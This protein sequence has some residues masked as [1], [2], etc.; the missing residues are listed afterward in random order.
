ML[1][2]KQTMAPEV[3]RGYLYGKL[4]YFRTHFKFRKE[5]RSPLPSKVIKCLHFTFF[6]SLLK[7]YLLFLKDFIYLFERERVYEQ[8]GGGAEGEA[9]SLLDPRTPRSRPKPKADA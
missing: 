1:D 7:V 5:A 9:D 6:G 2:E 8:G 3:S 4:K